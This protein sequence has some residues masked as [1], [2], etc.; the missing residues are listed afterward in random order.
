MTEGG[1]A[2]EAG[3]G[4]ICDASADGGKY[5]DDTVE[6]STPTSPRGYVTKAGEANEA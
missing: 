6:F 1:A 2:N 5:C 4:A 3:A